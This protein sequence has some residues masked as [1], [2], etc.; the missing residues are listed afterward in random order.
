MVVGVL[1][2]WGVE[3]LRSVCPCRMCLAL[4]MRLSLNALTLGLRNEESNST[5]RANE[6][7]IILTLGSTAVTF[8]VSRWR[9][10]SVEISNTEL[11]EQYQPV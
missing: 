9:S 5:L 1:G 8:L 4:T 6:T 11:D 7:S 10:G 3:S 2:V